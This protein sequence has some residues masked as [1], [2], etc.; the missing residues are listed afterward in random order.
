MLDF[1]SAVGA[2]VCTFWL[3]WLLARHTPLDR[4]HGYSRTLTVHFV[5]GLV[6]FVSLGL[7]K[8]YFSMFNDRAAMI[9]VPA[10]LFWLLADLA[11]GGIT[12]PR[13]TRSA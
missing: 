11:I 5:S 13:R 3:A 7:F 10:Q 9:M 6:L 2:V 12:I 8:G 4:L 1:W